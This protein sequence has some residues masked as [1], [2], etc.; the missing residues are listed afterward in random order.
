MDRLAE[1]GVLGFEAEGEGGDGVDD[2][3]GEVAVRDDV[4]A[5][6]G[7][8]V[9]EHGGQLGHGDGDGEGVQAG[10]LLAGKD[11]ADAVVFCDEHLLEGGHVGG[12]S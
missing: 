2:L 12:D 10:P 9:A 11:R 3:V 7:I 5:D 1:V 4:V 6:V 8:E